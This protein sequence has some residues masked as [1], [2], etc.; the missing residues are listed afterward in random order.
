[1]KCPRC[2]HDNPTGSSFCLECGNRLGLTCASCGTELPAGSKFCN[3]W[4][5]DRQA[6]TGTVGRT[7]HLSKDLADQRGQLRRKHPVRAVS[8]IFRW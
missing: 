3:R 5:E 6:I 8:S 2:Q 1:M 7:N 4:A